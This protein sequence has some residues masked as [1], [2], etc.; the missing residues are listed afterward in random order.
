MVFE[1][2]ADKRGKKLAELQERLSSL[3][4]E[5]QRLKES[6]AGGLISNE[7][8]EQAHRPL[9]AS[10]YETYRQ[11]LSVKQEQRGQAAKDSLAKLADLKKA[12]ARRTTDA[13]TPKRELARIKNLISSLELEMADIRAE[14][15][16][17]R[18]PRRVRA[19]REVKTSLP[20]ILVIVPV[21][22]VLVAAVL[23]VDYYA[24]LCPKV[25]VSSKMFR[26]I[27]MLSFIEQRSP[28]D[29]EMLCSYVSSLDYRMPADTGGDDPTTLRLP[30]GELLEPSSSDTD[31]VIKTSVLVHEGCHAMTYALREDAGSLTADEAERTCLRLQ[32][33]Y[34]Y[35]AGLYGKLE[36]SYDR[37]VEDLAA[38]AYQKAVDAY[39]YPTEKVMERFRSSPEN[40]Q[41]LAQG[42]CN[43]TSLN[44]SVQEHE[45]RA[46]LFDLAIENTG[47]SLI[48][49]GFI[50]LH[51]NGL[52][53]PLGCGVLEPGATHRTGSHFSLATNQ[54]ITFGVVGCENTT[55]S[56]RSGAVVDPPTAF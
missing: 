19:G 27:D 29:R 4:P 49:C 45:N 17:R 13:E 21:I 34:L 47:S 48:H 8:F 2:A 44:V 30:T 9:A 14:M 31:E 33:R 35:R 42:F 43:Q 26:L 25:S 3:V 50:D 20:N 54:S 52:D 56:I 38:N 6:V 40:R 15:E 39:T 18:P 53:Y 41:S 12:V 24:G 28:Q 5:E 1:D 36:R 7:E 32:Y 11:I 22:L 10:I 55:R 46:G 37:M 16:A 23:A 51:V